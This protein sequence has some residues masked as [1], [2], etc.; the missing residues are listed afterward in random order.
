MRT[1]PSARQMLLASTGILIG[2]PGWQAIAAES[3]SGPTQVETVVVT[4]QKRAENVQD[5]PISIQVVTSQ[6]LATRNQNDLGDLL[7]TVPG[8]SLVNR[9]S[10]DLLT[11]RGIGSGENGGF[12]QAAAIFDDDIYYGRSRL[13]AG[14]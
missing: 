5:V 1:K 3:D 11:I 10:S 7:Q 8:V 6:Q 2:L 13:S 14:A 12:D 4:A 9:A